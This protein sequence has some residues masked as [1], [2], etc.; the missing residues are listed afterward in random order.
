MRIA[1]DLDGVLA[2]LHR[3][4]A[5]TA[6][7]MFPELDQAAVASPETGA[8]PPTDE[9]ESAEPGAEPKEEN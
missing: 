8:S 4:F 6:L 1:F 5:A 9:A 2:D 7:R 3:M